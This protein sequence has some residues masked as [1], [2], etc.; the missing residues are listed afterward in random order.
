M[1]CNLKHNIS[2]FSSR[3]CRQAD[4][5]DIRNLY[6]VTLL[7]RLV[8][9]RPLQDTY[10]VFI[11]VHLREVMQYMATFL[12]HEVPAEV[13]L[14][15]VKRQVYHRRV[16]N[17]CRKLPSFSLLTRTSRFQ[18]SRHTKARKKTAEVRATAYAMSELSRNAYWQKVRH[19]YEVSYLLASRYSPSPSAATSALLC[20]LRSA[21][22]ASYV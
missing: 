20:E 9:S 17:S 19:C 3:L 1:I 18:Q 12:T 15:L 14:M 2:F 8:Y 13:R 7:H 22:S 11:T 21:V 5:Q 4:V 10:K 16:S 6:D